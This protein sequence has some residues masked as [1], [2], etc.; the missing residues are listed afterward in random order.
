SPHLSPHRVVAPLAPLHLP[1]CWSIIAI[2]LLLAV[3]T[4]KDPGYLAISY[5]ESTG[6]LV[7]NLIDILRAAAPIAMISVGMC[8]VIATAGID[9][10]VGSLMAVAGAVAMEFLSSAGGSVGAA[11]AA[12]G[13]A[14][15]FGAV[16]GAV[17]AVLISVVG[18]Q[19][20]ISTLVL[21]MAGRGL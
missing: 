16:L 6:N 21:M 13:L 11:F 10:S 1:Y 19:P 8:L 7:G 12:L 9:L 18:L 4:V 3:N 5:N 20:F 17:N 2:A 15:L 14:L